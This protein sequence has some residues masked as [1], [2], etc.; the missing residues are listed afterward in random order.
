MRFYPPHALFSRKI[1]SHSLWLQSWQKTDIFRAFDWCSG[2][3]G[4][5]YGDFHGHCVYISN[6]SLPQ[7]CIETPC[8]IQQIDRLQCILVFS[9]SS[10]SC[11]RFASDPWNILVLGPQVVSEIG[12]NFKIIVL[13]MRMTENYMRSPNYVGDADM[14]V[15]LCSIVALH[16]GA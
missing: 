7:K 14:D 16:G 3:D 2:R 10:W 13:F 1:C 9:S 6:K 4:D 8:T 15:H 12:K 5:F 11:L